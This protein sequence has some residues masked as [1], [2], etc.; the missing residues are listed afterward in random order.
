VG[1]GGDLGCLFRQ[2]LVL[3]KSIHLHQ[4]AF[5]Q[6]VE[7]SGI[8]SVRAAVFMLMTAVGA[9]H[10]LCWWLHEGKWEVLL[11]QQSPGTCAAVTT[12]GLFNITTHLLLLLV[13][14]KPQL[15]INW[16]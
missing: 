12:H 11:R 14:S 5:Q 6:D 13:S 7:A 10:Q 4:L 9:A 15:V 3:L 16:W 2:K 8:Q 1:G